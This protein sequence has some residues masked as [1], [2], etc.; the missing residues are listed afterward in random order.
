MFFYTSFLFI[1]FFF[2]KKNSRN[3]IRRSMAKLDLY[4][5]FTNALAIFVVLS[6]AWI[7]YE[8][9]YTHLFFLVLTN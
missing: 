2:F 9:L 6:I 4:R 8:V 5:K 3:Q 7:G 1:F